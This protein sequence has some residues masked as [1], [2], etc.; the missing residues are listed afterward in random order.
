MKLYAVL[1]KYS[2]DFQRVFFDKEELY[3]WLEDYADSH[4]SFM[5]YDVPDN[6]EEE[7]VCVWSVTF[8]LNTDNVVDVYRGCSKSKA[9]KVETWPRKYPFRVSFFVEGLKSRDVVNEA[10]MRFEEFKKKA[11]SAT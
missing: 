9:G 5:E 6:D 8:D 11:Q 10:L 3:K 1:K 2:G 4:T 7:K